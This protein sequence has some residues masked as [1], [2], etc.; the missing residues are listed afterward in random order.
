M[1]ELDGLNW[2]RVL[3][4]MKLE[5]WAPFSMTK[6]A[7]R[8]YLGNVFNARELEFHNPNKITAVLDI[9]ALPA[10]PRNDDIVYFRAEFL[11]G[12]EIPLRD[13]TECIAFL[14]FCY[15][16]G[17]TIFL[18]CA[19]GMSRS[20]VIFASFMHYMGF[21]DFDEAVLHIQSV[22]PIVQPSKT[23]ADSAKRH[24]RI[25]IATLNGYR[26]PEPGTF[27][28]AVLE[29][30]KKQGML[31]HSNPDCDWRKIYEQQTHIPNAT[32]ICGNIEGKK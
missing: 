9:S 15:E 5:W 21:M 6:L 19:A 13:F 12:H 20:P 24:L 14:K 23:V 29:V 32:C 10:Y 31:W 7:D 30:C 17:H 18:H 28:E 2:D 4:E 22:R 3:E 11:D 8:L 16:N 26:E 25:D 1:N 27:A